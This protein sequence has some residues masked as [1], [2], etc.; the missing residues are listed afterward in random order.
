MDIDRKYIKCIVE[1]IGLF[2][3]VAFTVLIV[4]LVLSYTCDLGAFNAWIIALC[5]IVVFGILFTFIKKIA[6]NLYKSKED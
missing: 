6:D 5:V 1:A 4:S 3:M 2:S